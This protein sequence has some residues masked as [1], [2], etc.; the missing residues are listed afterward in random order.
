MKMQP[1]GWSV[2]LV[3][4]WNPAILS[5]AGIVAHVL[6]LPTKTQV[7]IAVPIDGT[8]PYRVSNPEETLTVQVDNERLQIDVP[9]CTYDTL[10]KAM[11]A[12]VSAL[13]ALPMTPISA[14]GFNLNFRTSDTSEELITATSATIDTA[15]GAQG[16]RITARSLAR[17]ISYGTGQINLTITYKDDEFQATCNFH[18]DTKNVEDAKD[19]LATPTNSIKAEIAKIAAILNVQLEESTND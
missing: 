10:Q 6:E 8:S 5:P 13:K 18:L 12:G 19:W 3:G 9:K 17:K 1:S 4:R 11:A 15:I 16:Y 14:V 7:H 2:V